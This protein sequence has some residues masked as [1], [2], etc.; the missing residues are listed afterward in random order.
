ME[1]EYSVIEFFRNEIY[2][3]FACALK[4][5]YAGSRI[6]DAR[7]C[8]LFYVVASAIPKIHDIL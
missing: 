5:I 2:V 3:R 1:I 7:K 8:Q 6:S 4:Q